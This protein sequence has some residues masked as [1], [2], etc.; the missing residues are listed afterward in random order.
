MLHLR[1]VHR[2]LTKAMTIMHAWN[3]RGSRSIISP[4][5]LGSSLPHR[6]QK[7]LQQRVRIIILRL[8]ESPSIQMKMRSMIA[9]TSTV[10]QQPR[11]EM[12]DQQSRQPLRNCIILAH[13]TMHRLKKAEARC[14]SHLARTSHCRPHRVQ[15]NKVRRLRL[16]E[17]RSM[18]LFPSE[19]CLTRSRL[20]SLRH[21]ACS[22]SLDGRR[23][24]RSIL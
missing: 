12:V 17:P 5:H 7:R 8:T 2:R 10:R 14:R 1:S 11:D 6:D 13:H 9:K 15:P 24:S 3:H 16:V 18:E 20:I 19:K 21:L 23:R 22:R 4:L